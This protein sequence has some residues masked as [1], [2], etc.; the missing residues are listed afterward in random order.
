MYHYD[1]DVS[2]PPFPMTTPSNPGEIDLD[3]NATTAPHPQVV[4]AMTEALVND[5]HNPSSV[6]RAG[7][8]ARARV[9][10]ARRRV[11]GLLRAR[12]QQVTFTSGGTEAIDL[13]LRGTL[14]AQDRGLRRRFPDE[15]LPPPLLVTTAV[16]HAAVRDLAEALQR[17]H[18]WTC[19]VRLAPVNR[20]GVVDVDA[21]A[22]LLRGTEGRPR[23]T[24]IQWANNETGVIQ[25]IE[26]VQE[27]C[28]AARCALHCDGTQWVGKERCPESGPPADLLTCSAHKFHGPKGLGILWASRTTALAAQ[29]HG[30]Q[31]L[32]RRGGTENV[33]G[34]VGAGEAAWLAGQQLHDPEWPER[35]EA[36]QQLRDRLERGLLERCPGAVV[37]GREDEQGRAVTRLWN[38]TSIGFPRLESQVLLMM[39]SERGV[40]ASAGAACSSGSLDPSPVLLAMGVPMPVAHGSIRLSLGRETTPEQ[41]DRAIEIIAGAVHHLGASSTALA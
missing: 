29:L 1:P 32:G 38:T 18:H 15:P 23:V 17:D 9:E 13:A 20:A 31:E 33:P 34:I 5:W 40:L 19:E 25:P 35:R 7:Q 39:L 14:A 28:R 8:R 16:E 41:V 21:L 2:P 10:L 26:R 36:L 3:H 22:E 27:V 30:A 12:P 6:H 11:A 37:H 24:S 4:A